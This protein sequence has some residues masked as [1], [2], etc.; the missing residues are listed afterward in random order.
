MEGMDLTPDQINGALEF[1]SALLMLMNVRRLT[2]DKRLAGISLVPTLFFDTWGFW[3]LYYYPA[4]DQW[5]SFAGGA[6]L[7]SVN[8]LWTGLAFYYGGIFGKIKTKARRIFYA[9]RARAKAAYT[10]GQ[11]AQGAHG[12]KGET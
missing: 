6:C 12:E 8:V 2:K 5:W 1:G 4:L 9:L 3:N 10:R 7:V 11:E